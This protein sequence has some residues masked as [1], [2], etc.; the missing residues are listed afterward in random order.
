MRPHLDHPRAEDARGAVE[1]GEGLAELRHLPADAC[2]ALHEVDSVAGISELQG[3]GYA[4]YAATDDEYLPGERDRPGVERL[5]SHRPPD[6]APYQVFGLPGGS[7]LV[8]MHPRAMLP[9]IDQLKKIRVQASSL[10]GLPKGPLMHLRRTRCDDDLRQA[11]LLDRLHDLVLSRFGTSVQVCLAHDDAR[12]VQDVAGDGFAVDCASYVGAA[13]AHEDADSLPPAA[14]L[15]LL[16]H[17]ERTKM[18]SDAI[19]SFGLPVFEASASP[20][21]TMRSNYIY[22]NLTIKTAQASDGAACSRAERWAST[23]AEVH[24]MRWDATVIGLHDL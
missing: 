9:E 12:Q 2:L 15:R 20:K 1:S 11:M 3:G 5:E 13:P 24:D 7:G 16:I 23:G 8:L 14:L 10:K 19:L 17:G 6:P 4:R 22:H 18:N 21:R